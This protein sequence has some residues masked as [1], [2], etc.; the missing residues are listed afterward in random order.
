MTLHLN[1]HYR[2]VDGLI[3][4]EEG[5]SPTSDKR[6]WK[7]IKHQRQEAQGIAPLKS[8][9]KLEDDPVK[10][11][12]ILNAQFQS[13]FSPRSP[14]S[15][16]ALSTRTAGFLKPDG[17]QNTTPKMPPINITEEGIRKRLNQLN[18]H[19][20]AAPDRISPIVLKELADVISPVLTRIFR[21]SLSH[22]KTPDAWREAHVTPVFK[23]GEKYKAVTYRPVSLTC[24]LCKQM[25][26]ILASNIM[27]HLSSNSLLYDK[28]HGFHSERSCETQLLEFTDDVLKP[29]KDRKQYDTIIMDQ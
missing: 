7:F 27:V 28:Q 10:K 20:A 6:F 13:V 2:Y 15:L 17:K 3:T 23:K 16:K 25:E 21:A 4:D 14:L 18:P 26:H 8:N 24:I 12:N 29:L 1:Y 9:G 5:K 19:K 22:G 11:A